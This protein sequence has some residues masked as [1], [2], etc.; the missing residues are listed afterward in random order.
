[1]GK[2]LFI[3]GIGRGI[4]RGLVEE[5][6]K[7]GWEVFGV[8]RSNPFGGRVHF[9]QLDLKSFEKIGEKL[10][11]WQEI[12]FDLAILNAGVLGEIKDLGEW[13]IWELKEVMNV[14]VWANKILI[15]WLASHCSKIVAISSGASVNGN[16]GWGGYSI[17]KASLN[18]L[19][20][21]YSRE[22]SP[23]IYALAP[24]VIDTDMV[25]Q[26]ISGDREKFPSLQRVAQGRL[27]L[28][29]GVQL[30][31]RGIQLLDRYPSGSYVDVR[32]FPLP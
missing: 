11:G 31:K 13:S 20:K 30:V 19:V 1:M 27:P 3:T 28:R 26:V 23:P 29:E 22:I 12:P 32:D 25:R 24:G 15:D 16:R 18:M 9:S 7:E 4:G 17:S 21:I 10:K 5:Y 8:G 6:L 2:K 14:N